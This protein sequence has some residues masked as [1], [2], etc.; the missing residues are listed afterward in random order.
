MDKFSLATQDRDGYIGTYSDSSFV[1]AEEPNIT[2]CDYS[3]AGQTWSRETSAF[4]VW[5]QTNLT[6]SPRDVE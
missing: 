4:R 5:H 2:L 3:S 1:R 6:P